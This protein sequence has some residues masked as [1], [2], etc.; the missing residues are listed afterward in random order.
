M[1]RSVLSTIGRPTAPIARRLAKSL[2]RRRRGERGDARGASGARLSYLRSDRSRPHHPRQ[3]RQLPPRDRRRRARLPRAAGGAGAEGRGPPSAADRRTLR[4]SPRGSPWRPTTRRSG[5]SAEPATTAAADRDEGR[6]CDGAR[7]GDASAEA[8]MRGWW[9]AAVIAALLALPGAAAA[10]EYRDWDG[11][12]S[13]SSPAGARGGGADDGRR[14]DG[15][16]GGHLGHD[17]RRAGADRGGARPRRLVR[18][19]AAGRGTSTSAHHHVFVKLY[20]DHGLIAIAPY[21]TFTVDAT[22]PVLHFD[23]I[24]TPL[25]AG[26]RADRGRLGGRAGCLDDVQL[27]ARGG[28][29]RSRAA[30]GPPAADDARGQRRARRRRATAG[31]PSRPT[32]TAPTR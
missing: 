11:A 1:P 27:R 22:P 26:R 30:A 2:R 18:V 21:R 20:D 23:P 17:R 3:F 29:E 24:Q 5:R 12:R 19:R 15:D 13:R 10:A 31:T 4:A 9:G 25:A 28:P 14:G 16:T 6:P 32:P 7:G 8:T